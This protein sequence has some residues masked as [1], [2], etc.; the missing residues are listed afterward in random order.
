MGRL[1]L[2]LCEGPRRQHGRTRQRPGAGMTS[3]R[4][5][6]PASCASVRPAPTSTRPLRGGGMEASGFTGAQ[7]IERRT[8]SSCAAFDRLSSAAARRYSVRGRREKL[9]GDRR[10]LRRT[11]IRASAIGVA[12]GRAGL[13]G[14]ART[15][16]ASRLYDLQPPLHAGLGRAPC[17]HPADG[18]FGGARNS[19]PPPPLRPAAARGAGR[20]RASCRHPDGRPPRTPFTALA[21]GVPFRSGIREFGSWRYIMCEAP[22]GVLLELFQID[23]DAMPPALARYF[24]L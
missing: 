20:G 16:S 3:K 10:R 12:A 1:A 23:T 19:A 24:V 5:P 9:A 11:D 13:P 18:E 21:L 14:G 7:R 17:R 2:R 8:S 15:M 4:T 22:D 6:G